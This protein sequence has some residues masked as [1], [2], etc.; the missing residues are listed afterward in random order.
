V[1]EKKYGKQIEQIKAER[2]PPKDS[3]KIS[4]TVVPPTP[5][6]V[7]EMQ[8]QATGQNP[9]GY[10]EVTK[11]GEKTEQNYFL[12]GESYEQTTFN[13][14]GPLPPDLFDI[15]YNLGL[16]PPFQRRG[17]E[18]DAISIPL[19][20]VYGVKTALSDKTYLIGGND[21]LQRNIDQITS[22]QSKDDIEISE[23]LI[24]EKNKQRRK[25][26]M[27]QIFGEEELQAENDAAAE[28]TEIPKKIKSKQI[29]VYKKDD[30]K[31]DQSSTSGFIKKIISN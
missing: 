12:N 19:F 26:K 1:F 23:I 9:Y 25:E 11:F 16:Y 3:N 28:E 31:K 6:E 10:T 22:Q 13:P 30:G 15:T 7:E 27:A 5:R 2:K 4:A 14:A 29:D 24:R 20:D 21:A 17:M 8:Y 18:F